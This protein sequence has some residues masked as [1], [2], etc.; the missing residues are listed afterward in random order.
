MSNLSNFSFETGAIF[1]DSYKR[2]WEYK[3]AWDSDG[4]GYLVGVTRDT[5]TFTYE[6]L[7]GVA[8]EGFRQVS[9][10]DKEYADALN[11]TRASQ[12]V[13]ALGEQAGC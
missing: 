3:R 11:S 8:I 4:T 13:V 2:V 5:P 9:K 1:I 12:R 7:R 6:Q 10:E